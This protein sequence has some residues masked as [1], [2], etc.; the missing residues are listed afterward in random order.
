MG[1][2]RKES[3]PHDKAQPVLNRIQCPLMLINA[4]FLLIHIA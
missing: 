3:H 1:E 4:S 2:G